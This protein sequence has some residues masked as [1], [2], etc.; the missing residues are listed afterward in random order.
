[1]PVSSHIVF[2]LTV[3]LRPT[4]RRMSHVIFSEPGFVRR[5]LIEAHRCVAKNKNH[6]LMNTWS[7]NYSTLTYIDSDLH[8]YTSTS[9]A[10]AA[11]AT[12]AVDASSSGSPNS[13]PRPGS[14]VDA[15]RVVSF[16]VTAGGRPS[17]GCEISHSR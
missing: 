6:G 7:K 11:F 13:R 8:E 3:V 17:T 12:L 1:V 5:S 14:G 10:I 15:A 2:A 4:I 16:P 9:Y